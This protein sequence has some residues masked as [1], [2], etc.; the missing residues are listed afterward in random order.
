MGLRLKSGRDAIKRALDRRYL[1]RGE[2]AV[3]DLTEI[4]D[5]LDSIE[6]GLEGL[7]SSVSALQ[8]TVQRAEANVEDVERLSGE[9]AQAIERLLQE[10]LLL[11]R[12]L[13]AAE[14]S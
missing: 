5:R 1:T 14:P 3:L 13:D 6:A 4:V 8:C 7:R 2:A 12:D 10:E 11:R 9:C